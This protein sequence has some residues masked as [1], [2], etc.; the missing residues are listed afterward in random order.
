MPAA[1]RRF[2]ISLN[3]RTCPPGS[4]LRRIG[5]VR[6]EV[7]DGVIAPVVREPLVFEELIVHE[8][9]HR[10]QLDRG[11]AELLEIVDGE[12]AAEPAYVP[13]I[14]SGM[15]GQSLEKPFTCTS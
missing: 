2:T 10:Q 13:R 14:S 11:D 5:G 15:C 6:R 12:V 9:M 7:A 1:C 8:M 3:S 4:P